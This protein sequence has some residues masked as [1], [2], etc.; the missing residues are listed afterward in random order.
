MGDRTQLERI[1]ELEERVKNLAALIAALQKRVDLI[2][3]DGQRH[4]PSTIKGRN[5]A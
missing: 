2:I 3:P 4:K 5:G 1:Q